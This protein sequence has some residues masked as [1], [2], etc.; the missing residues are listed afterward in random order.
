MVEYADRSENPNG[1]DA[2]GRQPRP[3]SLGNLPESLRLPKGE[4]IVYHAAETQRSPPNSKE[5]RQGA[6]TMPGRL[7]T[8][9]SLF[10]AAAVHRAE[11]Q[12][13][14]QRVMQAALEEASRE[15]DR[16]RVELLPQRRSMKTVYKIAELRRTQ[17]MCNCWCKG[18]PSKAPEQHDETCPWRIKVSKQ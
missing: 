1:A 10:H 18:D 14:R 8:A 16:D 11:T 5:N 13:Q 2:A 9:I 6:I 15:R 4:T 7:A 3:E 12:E 17:P